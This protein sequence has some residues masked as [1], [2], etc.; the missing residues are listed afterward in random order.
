MDCFN[1]RI[2][3]LNLAGKN[4]D[5][6]VFMNNVANTW[7]A[8]EYQGVLNSAPNVLWHANTS[9]ALQCVPQVAAHDGSGVGL[10]VL[11]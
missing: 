9:G 11:E 2:D 7:P 5:V 10:Q 4:M 6:G 3:L 1:L 8:C